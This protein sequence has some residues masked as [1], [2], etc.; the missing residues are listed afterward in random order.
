MR[1]PRKTPVAPVHSLTWNREA[2]KVYRK[3]CAIIDALA[4]ETSGDWSHL[5]DIIAKYASSS[6]NKTDGA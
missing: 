5:E 6:T 3:L 2:Q 1:Q 4:K